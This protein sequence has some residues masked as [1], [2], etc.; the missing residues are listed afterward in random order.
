[1]R[2]FIYTKNMGKFL[3][4]FILTFLAALPSFAQEEEEL[5]VREDAFLVQKE[6]QIWR[7]DKTYDTQAEVYACQAV[8]L[9]KNWFLTA[10]HCVYTACSGS[11]PC[12]VQITL[13]EAEL[14]QTVRI[15]HSTSSQRVFI[16]SGFYPGQNRVSSVDA[17]LI[18]FDPET[19]EY[20]YAAQ[21]KNGWKSV[22]QEQFSAL[23]K[24]SPETKAQLSA[25]GVRLI[26]AANLGNSRFTAGIVVPKT[27]NGV[28]TY[29]QSPSDDIYFIEKLQYF[30]APGFGVRR[31]NSGGGVFTPQ[32]D[33]AGLVSALMYSKNGSAS[34]YDAEGKAVLTLQNAHDYFMFTGFNGATLNFIRNKVP[35]LRVIGADMGFVEPVHK[36]FEE[37]VQ[38]INGAPMHL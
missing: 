2:F 15:H 38:L 34:F 23:L 3:F 5:P 21:G 20:S 33:L 36:N 25:Y 35:S 29:L 28:V 10:A 12:T 31:G 16:Y 37:I 18:R 1:M 8:R 19:A 13:A 26:G 22:P 6:I 14:R 32:G 30:I 17:A 11:Q 24:D 27:V 7:T 9:H 4:L